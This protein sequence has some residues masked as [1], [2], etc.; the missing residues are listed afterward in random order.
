MADNSV[1]ITGVS[2][3]AFEKALGDLPPWATE[4]TAASIESI[5]KKT[6]KLQ[7]ETLTELVK[8]TT[9]SGSTLDVNQ[10]NDEL[11]TLIRNL[12]EENAQA[13]RNKR[14]NRERDAEHRR[15]QRRWTSDKSVFDKKL[16]LDS[17]IIK[18]GFAI[19]DVFDQNVK[20]YNA[21]IAS[22][23]NVVNGMDGTKDG[24]DSLRQLT[25]IT[26]VRFTELAASMQKYSSSVNS[27]GVGKF[28]KTVGMASSN[29]TR[30]GFSS[31]ESADLLG[32]Y[33]SVQQNV[34]DVSKKTAEETDKDLQN[35]G[36]SIFRLSLAT[37]ISRTAI[38]ANAEAISSS[39]EANLLAGQIG[40]KSAEGMTTF[41][42]SFKDQNVARQLLKLM[43]D[44]IKPL[45][46]S[47]M[48]LTKVG[49]GGFAQTF[50]SFTKSLERMPEETKQQALKSFVEAHRGELEQQKQRLA[51]L[52]H[53][54][55]E[56][57]A[58]LDFITGL[59]KQADI[60]TRLNDSEILTIEKSNKASKELA[61]VWEKLKSTLQSVFAPT[62]SMLKLF[63]KVLSGVIS[64]IEFVVAKFNWLGEKI[65]SFVKALGFAKEDANLDLAPW[66][67]LGVI[68]VALYKTMT[69][70]GTGLK[71]ML[72]AI[73]GSGDDRPGRRGRSGRGDGIGRAGGSLLSGIGKGIAGIGKG[74]GTG[75]G[76]MLAGLASGLMKLGNPRVLLGVVS[77]AGIAAALWITGKAVKELSEG[78]L[79]K[80]AIAL[81]ALGV[82]GAAAGAL[83]KPIGL[84]AVALGLMAGVIW[85]IGK[86]FQSVGYGL[87][88]ASDAF[89]SI[90]AN[91]SSLSGALTSFTGLSTLKSIVETINS[92]SVVKALAFGALG[93]FSGVSLP[94]LTPTTGV[95]A[96][97]TPKSSTLNSPSAV[98][99]D[100]NTGG[101]QATVKGSTMLSGTGIE[102]STID[103]N[104]STTL[105]YQNSLLSELLTSTNDLLSVNKDIL[106]ISKRNA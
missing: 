82:A 25:A 91:L 62:V 94:S 64:S 61:K 51:L 78:S 49:M 21:M 1:F 52:K 80:A 99:T 18:S 63:T 97:S 54:R 88:S 40:Q 81:G 90:S 77:L 42:A 104:L 8:K 96:S 27:F 23:V 76:K 31:K 66:I 68:G 71:H 50:T 15:Q 33:L 45:N 39:T 28:A 14:A 103:S 65:S 17:L 83:A 57:G 74:I 46:E 9:S 101:E 7:T 86:A 13:E 102:R 72:S 93:K 79:A 98:S 85:V 4:N 22:G 16:F 55:Q 100:K 106:R 5:L 30:F 87:Q 105:S 69:L 58:A 47:F 75:I 29:L 24:F 89:G 3:G 56:A 38:I 95:S 34:T 53:S 32:A 2:D 48:N 59:T 26:G 10:L 41:L 43:T 60:V 20:T 37:G 44:P 35:F 92:I 36:K 70:F 11:T 6:L 67:G 12:R 84:G 73:F 19:K